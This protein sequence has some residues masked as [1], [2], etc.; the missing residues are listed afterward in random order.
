MN[1][2]RMTDQEIES[3]TQ[4][5]E[6]LQGG[7]MAAA[8]LVACGE[9]AIPSLRD[10]LLRGRPRGI[11]Q[12]RQLA[13]ETLARLGAKEVL[14]EYLSAPATI[15]DPVVRM[16]EDAVRSTAARELGRWRSE[17]VFE[18]LSRLALD[19]I[20]P[21]VVESLG[22][23]RRIGSMPYFLLALGD[24]VCRTQ[25]E[26][27]IRGLGEAARSV[28]ID[29]VNTHTPSAEEETPSSFQRRR[30]ALR[31]LLDVGV[32]ERDW[33]RL[34]G[35]LAE[36]D[37][38]IAITAARIGIE[39]APPPVKLLAIQRIVDRLPTAG[40]FLRTEARA[41]LAEHFDLAQETVEAEIA[42]RRTAGT[43]E[44]ALDV[45]L[46]L[47]VNLR[48]QRAEADLMRR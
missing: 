24:G 15:K 25:A 42:R 20:L 12:P 21:G 44:Q 39:S 29:A 3:L 7:P 32:S 26:E 22:G 5:L 47:L 48:N 30:W 36:N 41:A 9:R 4:A 37:P 33:G 23:F 46:R 11:Y 40:W 14:I 8:A 16:G 2:A 6:S 19:S 35:L 13:V 31:I 34:E 17:D 10:Y 18:C 38:D 1:S 27:A 28:L 45:I 43:K